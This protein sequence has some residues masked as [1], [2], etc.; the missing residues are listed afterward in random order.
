MK[1]K[2][3][4]IGLVISQ[5]ISY[6]SLVLACV[7]FSGFDWGITVGF[8][9]IVMG[10]GIII[11]YHRLQSHRSFVTSRTSER[12]LSVIG[13]IAGQGSPISWVTMHRAHHKFTD[14][15][16]DPHSP[17]VHGFLWTFFLT[18]MAEGMGRVAMPRDLF[19]DKFQVSLHKHYFM[20][21]G[22][23][24]LAFLLLFGPHLLVATALC[25]MNSSSINT[26]GHLIGY[27]NYNREDT[28]TNSHIL[29][30]LTLGEGYHNN[31]HQDPSNYDFAHKG[32]EFDFSGW[33][34]KK[35]FVS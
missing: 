26:F 19:S 15:E 13:A 20:I 22:V 16:G 30:F 12:V 7:R 33:V 21:V 23:I 31:H 28:S 3:I 9:I 27:R 6:L 11:G 4:K 14:R 17:T 24:H 18:P 1:P 8:Y 2:H 29:A 35:L 25:W 5:I 10:F 34:I 32:K